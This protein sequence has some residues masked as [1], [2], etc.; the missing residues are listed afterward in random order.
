M[1]QRKMIDVPIGTEVRTAIRAPIDGDYEFVQHVASSTCKPTAKDRKL[2]RFRGQL[3]PPCP[4]CHKRAVW[5]LAE[6]KFE[7]APDIDHTAFVL[8]EVRGDRPDVAYP[9]GT[10]RGR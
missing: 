4:R 3:L 9:S 1:Q 10:K 6:Y 8:R 7:I 2:Y 5:K